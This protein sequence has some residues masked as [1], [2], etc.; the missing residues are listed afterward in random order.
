MSSPSV[1]TAE[2]A[3]DLPARPRARLDV[4]SIATFVAAAL[5]AVPMLT[6]IVI[7]FTPDDDVW[8][9]LVATVLPVYLRNTLVLMLGV[10]T[11]V[12]IIGAGTAWL[13]AMCRFPGRSVLA[14]GLVL[15]L[16]IPAYVIAYVYTDLLEFSGPVQGLLRELFGWQ[17]AH[18][19]WFPDIRSMGGAIAMLTLVFY[20]Y[21]YLLAR[22]AFLE[23]SVAAL[24]VSRTLGRGALRTF[25]SVALPLARPAIVVGLSLALMESLNDFGTVDY[26]AVQTLSLGIFNVWFG[27]NNVAGAAQ[28]ATA[29]LVVVL[30]IIVFERVMR[31]RRR[32]HQTSTT[33]QTLPSYRL[34]GVRAGLAFV[35]CFLPVVL[36]FLVPAAVLSTYALKHFGAAIED[37]FLSLAASSLVL[38]V[39][40]AGLAVA[41]SV[42]MAYG[43]RLRGGPV[44]TAVNRFASV[45]YAVP[46]AVLALGVLIPFGWLD[47]TVD[48]LAR[49]IAG[50]STGLLLSGTL[51]ALIFAYVVRF[52]AVSYG[53]VEASFTKVTVNMDGAARTL[54]RGPAGALWR[55]HVPLIKGSA[56]T[57]ALL[58]F[59]EVM[60]ELPMTLILRPFNFDT[61]ATYVYQYA[62]DE[63]LDRA[64]LAALAIVAVG[65]LPVTLLNHAIGRSRPG[66]S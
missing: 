8:A 49:S 10:G 4:W 12:F 62:G 29:A 32:F 64:A 24:E 33:Y 38:A 60:K 52:L 65:I 1:A 30:L 20:P 13:I 22:A 15:P 50:V 11:G 3:P 34:T 18:D 19:Y 57:A 5:V 27:M 6:V 51:I 63:Q 25:W 40:A 56:L 36:G 47:N 53:T 2:R 17:A 23:Q 59:I 39:I 28:I 9:H 42:T 66:S 55:V 14:W 37:K 41:V 58:V 54:G 31:G 21:L 16:A 7:A 45:G 35:A 43:L 61:L 48:G 44:L 46:G 26:F